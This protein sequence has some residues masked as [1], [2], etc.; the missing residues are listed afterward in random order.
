[1]LIQYCP[2]CQKDTGHG[3][4]WVDGTMRT[5]EHC[6]AIRNMTPNDREAL[7]SEIGRASC[8]ERV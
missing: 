7:L 4:R 6:D 3:T 1:M 8:R 2:N 5:D